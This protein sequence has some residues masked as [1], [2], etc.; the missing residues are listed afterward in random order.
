VGEQFLETDDLGAS[1]RRLLDKS[2]GLLEVFF[3]VFADLGLDEAD[4]DV[5]LLHAFLAAK[6][7]NQNDF[8]VSARL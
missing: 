6:S 3:D 5:V 2:R 1:S 7:G 8:S 4:L